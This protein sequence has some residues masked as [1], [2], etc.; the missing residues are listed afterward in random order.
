MTTVVPL[1]KNRPWLWIA[2]IVAALAV[3]AVAFYILTTPD[4]PSQAGERYIEDHYDALAEAAVKAALLDIPIMA[5]I[6]AEVVESAAERIVPYTCRAPEAGDLTEIDVRCTLSFGADAPL[7]L[8]IIAPFTLTIDLTGSDMF[9]RTVPDVTG[10]DLIKSE[11]EV[12]GLN[13]EHLRQVRDALVDQAGD[14][15]D[16]IQQTGDGIKNLID[17]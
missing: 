4:T 17:R 3:L 5:E 13:L 15:L 12:S 10:A 2:G 11:V 6:L 14:A 1:R 9:G 16:Q 7:N 8:K